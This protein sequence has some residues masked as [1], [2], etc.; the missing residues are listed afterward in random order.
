MP[1]NDLLMRGYGQRPP[2]GVVHI[3]SHTC[4]LALHRAGK[5]EHEFRQ[6]PFRQRIAGQPA[7]GRIRLE[8]MQMRVLCFAGWIRV[9]AVIGHG[10]RRRAPVTSKELPIATE[11]G[12]PGMTFQ[13]ADK[14]GGQ[15]LRLRAARRLRESAE[16][17]K[18]EGLPVHVLVGFQRRGAVGFDL[19]KKPP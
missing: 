11:G 14:L 15:R 8:Q 4:V 3:R 16:C 19:P 1:V 10:V 2:A 12:V 5:N 13:Q 18:P 7:V 17:I 9:V 6:S